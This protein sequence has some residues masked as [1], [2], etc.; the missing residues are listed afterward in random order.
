MADP[1]IMLNQLA[2]GLRP[3]SQGVAWFE[4]LNTQ[5]RSSTLVLLAHYCVQARAT[6]ED[7]PESIRRS[8]LRATHTPAVLLVRGRIDQQLR[9]IAALTPHVLDPLLQVAD[10]GT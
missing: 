1:H 2:Q 4:S 3:M 8:G 7:A 9:K 5:E 10:T 6:A